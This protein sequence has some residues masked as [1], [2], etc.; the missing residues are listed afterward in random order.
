[1]FRTN[2]NY[3]YQHWIIEGFQ[4]LEQLLQDS[5]GQFCFGHEATI[6]DCCLIP[7]VYNAKRF[8]IDLSAFPKIESIYHHCLSIPAFYNAAPEQQPDWE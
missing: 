3:W 6:A 1:M 8:K 5:N 4:N 2:K 7:Q